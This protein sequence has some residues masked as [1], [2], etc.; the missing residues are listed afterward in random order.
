[1]KVA[2]GWILTCFSKKKKI[3]ITED[4]LPFVTFQNTD[5]YGF[6]VKAG[7]TT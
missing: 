4:S 2:K 1:M 5:E 6:L 7:A 3:L